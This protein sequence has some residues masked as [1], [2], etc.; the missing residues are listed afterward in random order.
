[1]NLEIGPFEIKFLHYAKQYKAKVEQTFLS[2]L[3]E[4]FTVTGGKKTI[5]ITSDRPLIKNTG[6]RKKIKMQALNIN[7]EFEAAV[8]SIIEQIRQHIYNLEHPSFDWGKHPK[9]TRKQ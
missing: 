8:E 2:D 6:G 4:R 9:N 5:E 7:V 1:M 3:H